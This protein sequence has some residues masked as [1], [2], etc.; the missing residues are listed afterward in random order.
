MFRLEKL[1]KANPD[2]I[3]EYLT[4]GEKPKMSAEEHKRFMNYMEIFRTIQAVGHLDT[5]LGSPKAIQV[6]INNEKET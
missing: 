6:V 1:I 5:V 3:R 4:T 2:I